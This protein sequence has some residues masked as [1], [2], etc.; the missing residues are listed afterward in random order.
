MD[1][2]K[3][4]TWKWLIL[5]GFC[6]QFWFLIL[7][8]H[9]PSKYDICYFGYTTVASHVWLYE[10]GVGKITYCTKPRL[11]IGIYF[12]SSD[13]EDSKHRTS[14]CELRWGFGY[15]QTFYKCLGYSERKFKT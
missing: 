6:S 9:E 8:R 11:A 4:A 3:P 10:E 12:S 5:Y 1:K 14:K 2:I 15:D 7:A 13:M